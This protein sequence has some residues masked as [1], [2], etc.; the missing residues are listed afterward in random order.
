V[1]G[2]EIKNF[3][4]LDDDKALKVVALIYNAKSDIWEEDMARS[5]ALEEYLK[6]LKNR[7]SRYIKKSGIFN[8]KYDRVNVSKM[9]DKDLEDLYDALNP[10]AETY[11][12]DSAG[13]ELT[14][15]QNAKRLVYLTAI[16]SVA[17][18]LEKRDNTRSVIGVVGQVLITAVTVALQ[19]L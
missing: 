3:K 13:P 8:I 4:D 10:I 19:I 11:R 18:E 5:I 1:E 12:M 16:N 15:I 9:K 2:K 17:T 6:L 7:R 14:E